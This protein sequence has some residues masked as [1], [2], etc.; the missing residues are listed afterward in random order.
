MRDKVELIVDNLQ[1]TRK[2]ERF[3]P[4]SIT[5]CLLYQTRCLNTAMKRNLILTGWLD[6]NP[7][8]AEGVRRR[9]ASQSLLLQPRA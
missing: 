2:A 8:S 9:S 5:A 6:Y 1:T 3:S 7:N 4:A